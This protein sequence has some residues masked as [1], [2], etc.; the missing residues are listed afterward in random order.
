MAEG[1]AFQSPAIRLGSDHVVQ[2][3]E[4]FQMFDRHLIATEQSSK[5]KE[6]QAA[7]LFGSVREDYRR[8]SCPG[9]FP[10]KTERTLPS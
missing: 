4:F 9:I 3:W 10:P 8:Q 5:S 7:L 6:V 2:D 1:K